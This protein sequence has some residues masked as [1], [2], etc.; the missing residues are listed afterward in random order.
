MAD[1]LM[2]IRKSTMDAIANSI[3]TVSGKTGKLIPTAMPGEIEGFTKDKDTFLKPAEYPDYI[4][5][6][7]D[8]VAGEAR[9]VITSE[10]LVSICLSDSHYPAD[11]NTRASG[12]HAMMGI[13]ALTYLLPVDF[14]AHLGDVGYEGSNSETNTDRLESNLVEMLNYVRESAG[15]SI[16]LF[17][18]IGNHD[19]GDYITTDDSTDQISGEYL[20]NN[21]TALSASDNT[22]FSGEENGGYCYRDFTSKKIRV[23]LL[24]TSEGIITGGY[25]NDVGASTTQL[26]WFASKLKELNTK[27][28]AADWGIVV[29]CHYPA[30]YGAARPLSNVIAAYV[31]GTSITLDGTAYNFSGSNAAKFLVQHH[32]HI[33]NFLVD[34]LY[35]GSTPTQYEAWRVG[36]PNTQ[37]SRENYYGV[38]NGI[39]YSEPD[40]YTKDPGTAKDTSFVVNVINPSEEK[41]YSFCYGVGRDRTVDLKGKAY[42]SVISNLTGATLE[43]SAT[44]IEEG[45][46]YTGTI[47]VN[48]G[49]E[50]DSLVVTMGGTDVTSEVYADGVIDIASVTGNIVITVVAVAPPT[51]L[52]PLAI[53]TDSSIFNGTGYKSG[54]RLS[55]SDGGER[56]QSG[57]YISGFIPV[58]AGQTVTL[59][60]VGTETV[61][62]NNS[63]LIWYT[64]L[65]TSKINEQVTLNTVTANEDGSL[66]IT[67]P[68]NKTYF[69]L[70]SSYLGSDTEIYVK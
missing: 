19:P 46:S 54:Y 33:H 40:S 17:V 59:K 34:K 8:R 41:I 23:F 13:K 43:S 16:P 28:D 56:E 1:E 66:T 52:L 32:G 39:S 49:W 15:G 22:V 38:F 2:V 37:D 48:A 24:N 26:A 62:F 20:Y 36:I 27:S 42:Y 35:T 12:L 67:V 11:N 61:N 18:A 63:Y 7:V 69:R 31:N 21:F 47:T 50:L 51:N 60:N 53:D 5:T 44:T 25:S 6:E 14:I 29:L 10:S 55:T 45:S 4:R 65:D 9:K 3:R 57:M 70:S 58:S 64:A 30:D 68:S